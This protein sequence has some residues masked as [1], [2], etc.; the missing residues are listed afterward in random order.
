MPRKK[1]CGE[2]VRDALWAIGLRIPKSRRIVPEDFTEEER[3]RMFKAVLHGQV[4]PAAEITGWDG[5]AFEAARKL[6]HPLHA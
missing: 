1:L 6:R 4:F 5:R 3:F 2:P